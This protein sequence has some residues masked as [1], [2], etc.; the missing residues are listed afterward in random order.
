MKM[1]TSTARP[2]AFWAGYCRPAVLVVSQH[3][4]P[5]SVRIPS[6]IVCGV[7]PGIGGNQNRFISVFPQRWKDIRGQTLQ[8]QWDAALKAVM[9]HIWLRPGVSET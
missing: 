5:W 3:L 4:P 9:S 7:N 8:N 2:L 1:L 6:P